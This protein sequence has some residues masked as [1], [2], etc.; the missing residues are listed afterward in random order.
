MLKIKD[1]EGQVVGVLKDED[2]EPSIKKINR[3][4]CGLC[5]GTGWVFKDVDPPFNKCT[6][7]ERKE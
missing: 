1:G 6:E 3:R 2:T 4:Q 7:C 5:H